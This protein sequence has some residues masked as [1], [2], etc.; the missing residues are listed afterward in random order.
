MNVIVKCSNSFTCSR[1]DS[2]LRSEEFLVFGRVFFFSRM[3]V[4]EEGV[5]VFAFHLIGDRQLLA[6]ELNN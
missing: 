2:N 5:F 4:C 6:A 3:V 1:L